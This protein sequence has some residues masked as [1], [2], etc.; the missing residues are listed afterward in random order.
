MS[1]ATSQERADFWD[2]ISALYPLVKNQTRSYRD[3]VK[4]AL[5][6]II[7][8]EFDTVPTTATGESNSRFASLYQQV[9]NLKQWNDEFDLGIPKKWFDQLGAPLETPDDCLVVVTLVPYLK[10]K[11]GISGVQRTFDALWEIAASRQPDSFRG[12]RM[13]SGPKHLRLLAGIEHKPG[14]RWEVINLGANQGKA[15]KDVRSP[16]TSP[17]AGVLATA[18]HHPEY[19]RSQNGN[20][21]PRLWLPG[22]QV[23]VDDDNDVVDGGDPWRSVPCLSWNW[24]NREVG[25]D[26]YWDDIPF[27]DYAVPVL[28]GVQH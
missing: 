7:E 19:V 14:L 8:G 21:V 16:A 15:P 23:N 3:D 17:H 28:R 22:Y 24:I 2:Q 13:L 12:P 20:G 26:V 18:A 6:R 11:R 5:Q 9:N 25:L 4:P 1:M 10:G 27:P